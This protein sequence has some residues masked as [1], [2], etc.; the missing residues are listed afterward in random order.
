MSNILP[1]FEELEAIITGSNVEGFCLSCGNQQYGVEPDAREYVCDK[2][3]SNKV[4]GAE[5]LIMMGQFIA[6]KE[7]IL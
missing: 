4:F 6:S 7:T 5:E 3:G 1:T 2:C